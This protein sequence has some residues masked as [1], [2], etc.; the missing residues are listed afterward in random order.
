MNKDIIYLLSCAV[1]EKQPDKNIVTHMNLEQVYSFAS[2]HMITAIVA[3][4]L[5]AAGYKNECSSRAIAGSLR[6][7]TLFE[8]EKKAL[9]NRLE[10]AEIWYMP[11]KGAVLKDYYPKA[12]M[13][14]MSDYDI[15]FD[16]SRAKDVEKIMQN[17]NFSADSLRV[18]NEDVY[19]K[20]PFVIFEMHRALFGVRHGNT[21]NN[22]YKNVKQRL[23]KD[24]DNNFG[25]HFMP[26]DFYIYMTAHEYS[27]YSTAGTGLR[28]LADTYIYLQRYELNW[29]YIDNETE[30]LGISDFEQKNRQLSL[31]LFNGETLSSTNKNML[32]YIIFSGAY[33]TAENYIKND[34][35]EIGR[36]KYFLKRLTLPYS[37]ML[38]EY[39][40]LQKAPI[41]YPFCWLSRLVIRGL[42]LRRNRLRYQLR[43]IF[44]R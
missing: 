22:Y 44:K 10:E 30:K 3:A 1:N 27:H 19:H 20:P 39:P 12:F 31:S 38:E 14:E 2:K 40:I 32:E 29:N 11:L 15:L 34:M 16:A 43:A 8:K 7:I 37:Q 24:V 23:L 13:R 26:E 36:W 35:T 41:L 9:F 6:K 28:S 33:G 42:F 25:F 18:Q 21:I 5:E 17:L 4:A